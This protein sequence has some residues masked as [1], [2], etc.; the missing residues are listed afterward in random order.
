MRYLVILPGTGALPRA[1]IMNQ[2]H[3]I[4][5]LTSHK[6][7]VINPYLSMKMILD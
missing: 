2:A 6:S 5:K 7:L 4:A 1:F 3:F